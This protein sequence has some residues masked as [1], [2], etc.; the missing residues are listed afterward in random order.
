[1]SA[2]RLPGG[3][4]LKTDPAFG[5]IDQ[6]YQPD[7]PLLFA[8]VPLDGLVF[9][10]WQDRLYSVMMW[11]NGRIGYDRLRG[12]IFSAFGRGAQLKSDIERYVWEEPSTQRMLELDDELKTGIF[13]MRSSEID[14]I[15]KS[16]YPHS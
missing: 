14:A 3:K 11:A 2:A 7:Q 5:G 16:R 10:F 4:K 8:G 12:A 13:I 9:G 6:Y 15:I 1:M